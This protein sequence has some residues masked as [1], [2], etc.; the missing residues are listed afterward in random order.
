MQETNDVS[1]TVCNKLFGNKGCHWLEALCFIVYV[2]L[3]FIHIDTGI[4]I[5][6]DSIASQVCTIK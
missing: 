3:T 2:T 4:E 5:F 6:L 1:L